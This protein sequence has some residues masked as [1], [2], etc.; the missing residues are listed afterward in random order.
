MPMRDM[1]LDPTQLYIQ[2]LPQLFLD[3]LVIETVQD[4][5]RRWHRPKRRADAPV[6]AKDRP[7]E[8][9]LYFTYSN[10]CVLYDPQDGLCKCWYEDLEGPL[11]TPN[12]HWNRFSRQLYAESKDGFEWRKPELDVYRLDGHK[13]NIV[14]GDS[15][16]GQVHSAGMVIDKHPATPDQRFRTIYSHMWESTSHRIE[17]AHSPDGIHWKMYSAFPRFGRSGPRLE[18]VLVPMYDDEAQEFILHTRHFLQKR[19]SMNPMNPRTPFNR[20]SFNPPHEPHSTF[21]FNQRRIW[22]SRSHDF[23]HWTEP[24]P[25]AAADDEEDNLDE[26]FYGM[27]SFKV[28]NLYLGTA[29]VLHFVDNTMDVQLMMS[30]DGLHWKRTNKRQSFLE[31]RGEGYWDAYMVSLPSAPVE[32]G[33]ELLFFHGGTNYHHDWWLV[34]TFGEML[35]HPEARNPQGVRF[36]MGV[37]SLRKDG[38]A[39]LQANALREGLVVTRPLTSEGTQ[40][41]INARCAR[42]GYVRVEVID[43]YDNVVANCSK[44]ACDVFVGDSVSHLM[45]WQGSS[46]AP[47]QVDDRPDSDRE[48]SVP[49]ARRL[50]FFLCDAE[51][52]SFRFAGGAPLS[53]GIGGAGS[54]LRVGTTGQ[55]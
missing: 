36:G 52:F 21:S 35:D 27:P 26:S 43:E 4:I 8:H 6:I 30:R 13:T 23:I 42:G 15:A 38:F 2:D 24:I 14:L 3:N 28:G 48:K 17:A 19:A 34:P 53:H 50:R 49:L 33:D 9:S 20:L 37:A 46:T 11:P 1:T 5:T 22:Q 45:T 55:P 18:D 40:L 16:Y 47:V 25:V 39:G 29:G 44:D 54:M 12:V 31:P 10:F 32:F 51:L 7:W 41:Y